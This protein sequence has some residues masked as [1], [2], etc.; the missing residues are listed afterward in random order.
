MD[1]NL[2][3]SPLQPDE[4]KLDW[5]VL[6][7]C[8]LLLNQSWVMKD[9]AGALWVFSNVQL[10]GEESQFVNSHGFGQHTR[11]RHSGIVQKVQMDQRFR[12]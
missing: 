4:Y 6:S 8:V 10:T 3:C 2:S 12:D 11:I 7:R 9:T 1:V 5:A